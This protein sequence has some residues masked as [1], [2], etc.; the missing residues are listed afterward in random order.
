MSAS[1]SESPPPNRNSLKDTK[2]R[3]SEPRPP[4]LIK[5]SENES[6]TMSILAFISSITPSFVNRKVLS[7][8]INSAFKIMRSG[9]GLR[10]D[11]EKKL[12][13]EMAIKLFRARSL[14]END[15]IWYIHY[16]F[17][18]F[19]KHLLFH[20]A[21]NSKMFLLNLGISVVR[22]RV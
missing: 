15:A 20:L 17:F 2:P 21:T 13:L 8:W 3:T 7:S 16:S 14:E 1:R 6:N 9:N 11:A 12:K 4:L 19:E 18:L 5:N 22:V 10:F